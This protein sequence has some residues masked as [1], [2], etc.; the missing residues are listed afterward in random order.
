[1]NPPAQTSVNPE[2]ETA[3]TGDD[4]F[5]LINTD[6]AWPVPQ[7]LLPLTVREPDTAATPNVT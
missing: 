7:T 6:E 5:T 3:G 1:M 2:M 4:V